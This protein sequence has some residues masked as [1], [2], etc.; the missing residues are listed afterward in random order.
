MRSR[1]EEPIVGYLMMGMIVFLLIVLAIR[2]I[3]PMLGY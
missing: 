2:L 1:Y 3:G